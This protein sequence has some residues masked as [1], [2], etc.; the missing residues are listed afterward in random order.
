MNQNRHQQMLVLIQRRWSRVY[1]YNAQKSLVSYFRRR[2]FK[3]TM[4]CSKWDQVK[5]KKN[6]DVSLRESYAF[7]QKN[8]PSHG[9]LNETKFHLR[10]DIFIH[11]LYLSEAIFQ[12]GKIH[13]LRRLQKTR[14]WFLCL[15]IQRHRSLEFGSSRND[16]R[17][18]WNKDSNILIIN[19]T[20]RWMQRCYEHL[21]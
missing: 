12:N 20:R 17:I 15:K 14:R 19:G 7:N 5:P 18:H 4:Y 2:M 16:D 9:L 11:P 21:P 8:V 6:V 1:G 10:W 13:F 3:W